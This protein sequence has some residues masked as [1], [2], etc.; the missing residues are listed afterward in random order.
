MVAQPPG[1]RPI[2]PWIRFRFAFS[3]ENTIAIKFVH[4]RCAGPALPGLRR[5]FALTPFGLPPVGAVLLAFCLAI[6]AIQFL[7]VAVPGG[8]NTWVGVLALAAFSAWRRHWLLASVLLG[9]AWGGI[10]R[11]QQARADLDP[12]WEGV[13]LM[14][15]GRIHDLPER[16]DRSARFY[17]AVEKLYPVGEPHRF[18]VS[19]PS[20]IR[21]SWHEPE[22]WPA[23]GERWQFEVRLKRPRG[24]ANPHGF[25]YAAWL[26]GREC[27]PPAMHVGMARMFDWPRRLLV[28]TA[29]DRQ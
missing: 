9:L 22:Q 16:R 13:N 11:W 2:R 27:G 14:A 1:R 26:W 21:L 20:L 24:F 10:D 29:C 19:P 23:S 28:S 6:I 25:D 15:V 5:C 3:K 18:D 7:P 12:G 8:S 17:L 4:R